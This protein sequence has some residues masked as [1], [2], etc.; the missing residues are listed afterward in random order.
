M[1]LPKKVISDEQLGELMIR[2]LAGK[3]CRYEL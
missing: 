2:E 3:V 1:T